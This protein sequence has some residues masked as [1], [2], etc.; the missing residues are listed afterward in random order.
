VGFG[1]GNRLTEIVRTFSKT[2][3]TGNNIFENPLAP[4]SVHL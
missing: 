2:P 1:V 4:F 3:V